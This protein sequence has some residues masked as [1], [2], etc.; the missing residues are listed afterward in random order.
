MSGHAGVGNTCP[1]IVLILGSFKAERKAVL[2]ALRGELRKKKY[3]PVVFDFE[4][5]ASRST[6][7]PAGPTGRRRSCGWP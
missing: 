1:T 3:S 7:T 4:K 2:D 5:P 6:S